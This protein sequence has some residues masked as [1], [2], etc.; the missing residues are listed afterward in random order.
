MERE[1]NMAKLGLG[2]LFMGY[3]ASFPAKR[4]RY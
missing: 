2:Y 3:Y 4:M 1:T